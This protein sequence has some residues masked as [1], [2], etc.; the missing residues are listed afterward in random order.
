MISLLLMFSL[1]TAWS[2]AN[3][4]YTHKLA[5]RPAASRSVGT[6]VRKCSTCKSSSN[7]RIKRNPST[8]RHKVATPLRNRSHH[9]PHTPIRSHGQQHPTARRYSEIQDALAVK[10]YL[11]GASTGVWNQ[12]S[13]DAMRRFQEDQKLDP[14]GRLTAR[15]LIALGLGP[16]TTESTSLTA[17]ALF[18]PRAKVAGVT[19]APPSVE[20]K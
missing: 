2:K 16:R 10:G 20:T 15:S 14:T 12:E 19:S 6:R 1:S 3:R 9:T 18:A 17:G 8:T 5:P 11:N 13:A 4:G 7:G